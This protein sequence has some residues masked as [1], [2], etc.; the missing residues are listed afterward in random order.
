MTITTEYLLLAIVVYFVVL[1]IKNLITSIKEAII[2]II[3]LILVLLVF[4]FVTTSQ[5][6]EIAGH[7]LNNTQ[8]QTES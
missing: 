4:G 3:L 7:I 6:I 5:L 2:A 1:A 8:N